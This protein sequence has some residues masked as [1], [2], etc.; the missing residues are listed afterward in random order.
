MPPRFSPPFALITREGGTK[1]YRALCGMGLIQQSVS[2]SSGMKIV[3]LFFTAC[4]SEISK[5][6]AGSSAY[7]LLLIYTFVR[8]A[9][10]LIP[11]NTANF[12]RPIRRYKQLNWIRVCCS[13]QKYCCI[14]VLSKLCAVLGG[15]G[16]EEEE[17]EEGM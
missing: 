10:R 5:P 17:E 1:S 8:T 12:F 2:Q 14:T 6:N 16:E 13:V 11:I 3:D 9:A 15:G 4:C 7:R